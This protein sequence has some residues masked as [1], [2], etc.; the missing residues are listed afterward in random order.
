MLMRPEASQARFSPEQDQAARYFVRVA[1]VLVACFSF[2]DPF[3]WALIP[4]CILIFGLSFPPLRARTS[5]LV[6]ALFGLGPD[7][8]AMRR[9]LSAWFAGVGIAI[10]VWGVIVVV[11]PQG[12]RTN[13]HWLAIPASAALA[14][15]VLTSMAVRRSRT[16]QRSQRDGVITR[17]LR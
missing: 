7:P 1:S 2:L 6:L 8:A 13:Q 16:A 15:V 12:D 3:L 11:V 4:V 10:A 17:S 5:R 9:L 14:L